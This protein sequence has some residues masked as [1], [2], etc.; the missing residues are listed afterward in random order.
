MEVD[1][2]ISY[3]AVVTAEKKSCTSDC[4]SGSVY[5]DATFARVDLERPIQG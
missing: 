3:H 4:Q 5:P 2:I 1:D